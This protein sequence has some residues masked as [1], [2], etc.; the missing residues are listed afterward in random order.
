MK[1]WALLGIVEGELKF[2][3]VSAI[4]AAEA[5]NILQGENK[6]FKGVTYHIIEVTE[7]AK[8]D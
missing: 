6:L 1:P 4:T 3:T 2:L 5:F 7:T 8:E